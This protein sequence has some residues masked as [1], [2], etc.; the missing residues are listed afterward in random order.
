M[1]RSYL[2]FQ[3][4]DVRTLFFI[5]GKTKYKWSIVFVLGYTH[6]RT[7]IKKN[8]HMHACTRAHTRAVNLSHITKEDWYIN[9]HKELFSSFWGRGVGGWGEGD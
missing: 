7:N 9:I 1:P 4:S 6:I 8:V 2:V 3:Q 5:P